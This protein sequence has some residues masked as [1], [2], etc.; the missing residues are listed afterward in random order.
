[1]ERHVAELIQQVT[2][3]T[4]PLRQ[5]EESAEQARQLLEAHRTAGQMPEERMSRTEASVRDASL[6]G[7]T[8][9]VRAQEAPGADDGRFGFGA[10]AARYQPENFSFEDT[11]WRDWSRV[12]RTWAGRF[13]RGR[14]REIIRAVEARPGEEA[15]VIEFDQ[16]FPENWLCHCRHGPEQHEGT[17]FDERHEVR[18]LDEF[19]SRD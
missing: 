19:C 6:A 13:Q 2:E 5:N 3:M 10:F 9:A 11:G 1:M 15:S 18:Q 7:G 16:W 12:F 8:S 17:S 14:V 4:D